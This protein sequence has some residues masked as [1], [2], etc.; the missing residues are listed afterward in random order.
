MN[1]VTRSHLYLTLET[2]CCLL[3]VKTRTIRCETSA[4]QIRLKNAAL[5]HRRRRIDRDARS[6]RI[7]EALRNAPR[8]F[9]NQ[10]CA[11]SVGK[12]SAA[13]EAR[14]ERSPRSY[15]FFP[16]LPLSL[17]LSAAFICPPSFC[18]SNAISAVNVGCAPT[19]D[20]N[21]TARA[22]ARLMRSGK[23]RASVC[24]RASERGLARATLVK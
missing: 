7:G 12:H 22:L 18:T 21:G 3:S 14:T 24:V 19:G 6:E 5:P 4:I 15:P 13:N 20:Y 16:P 1:P 8:I 17:A 23:I 9:A 10:L 2:Y 11:L